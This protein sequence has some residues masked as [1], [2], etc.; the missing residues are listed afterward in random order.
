MKIA[1]LADIHANDVA[2]EKCLDDAMGRGAREFWFLGDYVGDLAGVKQTMSLINKIAA[3]YPCTFIRGNKEDY[4]LGDSD[5]RS[6]WRYG[7]NATGT[8]LYTYN[9]LTDADRAMFASLPVSTVVKKDRLS[10]VLLCHGRPNTNRRSLKDDGETHAIMENSAAPIIICG[11]THKS[12]CLKHAGVTL[13][14]CGSVGVSFRAK[15]TEYLLLDGENAEWKLEQR[16]LD[17]DVE[18]AIKDMYANG[19]DTIAP[20]WTRSTVSILR[21]GKPDK[22]TVVNAVLGLCKARYGDMEYGKVPDDCWI[23]A[24]KQLGIE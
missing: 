19:L 13:L 18:K 17:Y 21:Y 9:N 12:F 14:N 6:D 2:F 16:S 1:V 22:P 24:L 23:D 7:N 11:H 20:C 4:W 3:E 8:M 10:P 5:S 15:K